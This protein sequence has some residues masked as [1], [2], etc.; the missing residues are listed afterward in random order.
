M[1]LS[2]FSQRLVKGLL[3]VN[4]VNSAWARTSS[5]RTHS[6]GWKSVNLLF[7]SWALKSGHV[8]CFRR[9]P[10]QIITT[11]LTKGVLPMH[12]ISVHPWCLFLHTPETT[13]V[14][15][16]LGLIV[17]FEAIITDNIG[18]STLAVRNV[19][20]SR[21][22]FL[23]NGRGA[24]VI[25]HRILCKGRSRYRS[26]ISSQLIQSTVT[27]DNISISSLTVTVVLRMLDV[28]SSIKAIHV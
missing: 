13:F 15:P 16:V 19:V 10:I 4:T 18:V 27:E 20:E 11:V 17:A 22:F 8:H 14:S 1:G 28:L 9:R 21:G 23:T 25:P 7:L 12:L 26:F 3:H 6:W 24:Y 5:S 2:T